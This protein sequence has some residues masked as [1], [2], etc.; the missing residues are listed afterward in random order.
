[1]DFL[2]RFLIF[3]YC[4][5][6][7]V[8]SFNSVYMFI[9]MLAVVKVS[10]DLGLVYFI[11]IHQIVVNLFLILWASLVFFCLDYCIEKNAKFLCRII[12]E[13]DL[14]IYILF[15][16]YC[17]FLIMALYVFFILTLL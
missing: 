17:L 11:S 15:F 16:L 4:I 7:E 12:F 2:G 1:M 10:A 5:V 3:V 6:I 8:L 13:F 14:Y 9:H